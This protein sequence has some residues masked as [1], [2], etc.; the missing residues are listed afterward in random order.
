MSRDLAK[1]FF[2]LHVNRWLQPPAMKKTVF[3]FII[4]PFMGMEN[5]NQ[6][7]ALSQKNRYKDF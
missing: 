5:T 7:N 4:V 3:Q 6:H 1:A 2:L